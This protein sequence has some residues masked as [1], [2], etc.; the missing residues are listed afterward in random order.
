MWRS[1]SKPRYFVEK[2]QK[3]GSVLYYWQPS[4]SLARAGFK[5]V[6]LGQDRAEAIAQAEALNAKVDQWRGGLPVLGQEPSRHHPVDHRAVQAEPAVGEAAPVIRRD[7][8]KQFQHI[9]RWSAARGDPPMRT[10]T[11]RDAEQLWASL[12]ERTPTKRQH[13]MTVGAALELRDRSR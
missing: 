7:L 11:R 2:P 9:L 6:P 12:H 1:Q 13:V 3:G 5:T 8:R 4:A 10:I